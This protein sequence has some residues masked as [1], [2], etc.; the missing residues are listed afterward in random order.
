MS[1]AEEKAIL[2]ALQKFAEAVTAKT[3]S[4]T[5]GEPED[6]LRAPFEAFMTQVGQTV[7]RKIV[8]T[9]ETRLAGRLGKPDYAIHATN[10]LVGYVELKAPGYGAKPDIFKGRNR[11]QWKRFSAI[12][13][14]IYCDGN[15]W[16]LYRDGKSVRPVVRLS[17]DIAANG[18]KAVIPKD[19]AAVLGLL[20]EFLSWQPIIPTTSKGD[21]DLRALAKLLVLRQGQHFGFTQQQNAVNY[22]RPERMLPELLALTLH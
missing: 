16:G 11:E 19:A 12:P 3:T 22:A 21:I 8:C 9:G 7:G 10:L 17:G 4:L 2:A 14:L 18:K 5:V 15:D 20:T 6:Q 1:A 13:N